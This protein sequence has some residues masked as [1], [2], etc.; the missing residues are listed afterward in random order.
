MFLRT[1]GPRAHPRALVVDLLGWNV[2]M[3]HCHLDVHP[4]MTGRDIAEWMRPQD[5]RSSH[6]LGDV[7]HPPARC[8]VRDA[9]NQD[10]GTVRGSHRDVTR[11]FARPTIATTSRARADA[12]AIRN[13]PC[14]STSPWHMRGEN[15]SPMT[16]KALFYGYTYRW[17]RPGMTFASHRSSSAASRRS[18]RSSSEPARARSDTGCP[19]STTHHCGLVGVEHGLTAPLAASLAA[20]VALTDDTGSPETRGTRRPDAPGD[21]RFGGVMGR[22]LLVL[23]CCALVVSAAAPGGAR[24]H[25]AELRRHR[26]GPRVAHPPLRSRARGRTSC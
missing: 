16:R 7:D 11:T 25:R 14:C 26:H 1:P 17:V 12:R 6:D 21:D 8:G 23:M 24:T 13:T 19:R 4:P 20:S 9:R 22:R 10:S 2:F 5:G 15:R 18:A 3:H